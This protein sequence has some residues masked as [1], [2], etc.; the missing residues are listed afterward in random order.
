MSGEENSNRDLIGQVFV[1]RS[2]RSKYRHVDTKMAFQKID[3]LWLHTIR[4]FVVIPV[5]SYKVLELMILNSFLRGDMWKNERSTRHTAHNPRSMLSTFSCSL[6]SELLF[7]HLIHLQPS[8][9]LSLSLKYIYIGIWSWII[10]WAWYWLLLF[11][12]ELNEI[13]KQQWL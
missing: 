12:T 6:V 8:S 10:W 7:H 3:I 9:S 5:F 13:K 2:F 11:P 1:N 4:N